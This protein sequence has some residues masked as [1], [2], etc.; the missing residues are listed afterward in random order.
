MQLHGEKLG[1]DKLRLHCE[2]LENQL[3]PHYLF[4]NLSTVIALIYSDKQIAEDYVRQL[5]KTYRYILACK[6][7]KTISIKKELDFI[8]AYTFLMKTRYK[9]VQIKKTNKFRVEIPVLAG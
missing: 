6:N 7:K 4:N 1:A 8:D 3:K 5:A 2:A 9:K